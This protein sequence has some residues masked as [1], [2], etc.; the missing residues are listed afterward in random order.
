MLVRFFTDILGAPEDEAEQN[1]CLMEHILT[2]TAATRLLA[3]VKM[4]TEHPSGRRFVDRFRHAMLECP[5]EGRCELCEAY[6]RCPLTDPFD[7][8]VADA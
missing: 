5:E 2:E 7:G 6:E 8:E 4:L 3:F 1:A